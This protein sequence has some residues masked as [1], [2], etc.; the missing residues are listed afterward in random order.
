[1]KIKIY[2]SH[3]Q[4]QKI[5]IF[6]KE[7]FGKSLY[8]N[9]IEQFSEFDENKY[10]EAMSN[11]PLAIHSKPE[12]ILVIGGGDG[13]VARECLKNFEVESIDVCEID[14]D[15]VDICKQHFPQIAC[16]FE[17]PKVNLLYEDGSLFLKNTNKKYDVIIV[18]STDPDD[19]S[20][21]LF[22][23][24][25]YQDLS[26]VSKENTII[27]LQFEGC[28]FNS[29]RLKLKIFFIKSSY[30]AVSYN[31]ICFFIFISYY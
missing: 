9:D 21:P 8:L 15:V 1:M 17:N 7:N 14:K 11:V 18:D 22:G 5:Q 26:L 19:T 10:H 30:L 3:S 16:S 27:V 28:F 31:A 20:E 25:F 24:N 12:H 2:E 23:K 13:G 4:Y 29:Q 6:Q